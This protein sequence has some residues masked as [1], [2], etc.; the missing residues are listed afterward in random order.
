MRWVF[1]IIISFGCLHTRA[2]QNLPTGTLRPTRQ[3]PVHDPVMIREKD[4]YYIFAT[5]M[6]IAVW[7]SKDLKTWTKELPVFSQAPQW[8][9]DTIPGFKGHIWAP[10][11]IFHQGIYYLYYSVSAFG[12][13]TSAIGVATNKTL[14]PSSPECKWVDHGRVIQSWPGKNN[15]NAIDPNLVIDDKGNAFMTFGSFWDGI[16]MIRMHKDLLHAAEP[17]DS[18]PT[19]ASRRSKASAKNPP[20]LDDHPVDTGANAIEAPFIFRKGK[21]YYLFASIDYCCKGERSTYKVIVG[22]SENMKGPFLDKEGRDLAQGGGSI[23]LQGNKDWHGAGHNAVYSEKDRD[24]MI[25]HAYDAADK[26]RSKLQIQLIL[27][28]KH[29]WPFII[30]DT[31]K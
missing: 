12:K 31:E 8:A 23:V 1:I 25:Y 2:Q 5:G 9:L 24:Y 7:S 22:R 6:G 29:G 14:D 18:L 10:D 4:S 19:I 15:W 11:I 30:K 3:T 28:D 21:Y 26:G 17:F 16:K 20:A 13:N 27:W